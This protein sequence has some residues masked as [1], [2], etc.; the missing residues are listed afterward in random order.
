MYLC[1]R[2]AQATLTF[3]R[4]L[5]RTRRRGERVGRLGWGKSP[6]QHA[7]RADAELLPRRADWFWL[8]GAIFFGG[9]VG[10]VALMYGLVE[11]IAVDAH[12]L[13]HAPTG[14][15]LGASIDFGLIERRKTAVLR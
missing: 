10:P 15:G 2:A 12:G 3:A 11:D 14:P 8:A 9:L 6:A 5:A 1:A 4:R 13:V 7:D